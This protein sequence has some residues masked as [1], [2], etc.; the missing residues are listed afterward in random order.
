MLSLCATC[1]TIDSLGL[2]YGKGKL[3]CFLGDPKTITDVVSIT[4]QIEL[5][6]LIYLN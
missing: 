4:C 6:V 5:Y 3:T 1:R 2:G